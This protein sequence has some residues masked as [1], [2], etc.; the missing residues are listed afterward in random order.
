M[1]FDIKPTLKCLKYEKSSRFQ[2]MKIASHMT[3]KNCKKIDNPDKNSHFSNYTMTRIA[4]IWQ[5]DIIASFS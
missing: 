4:K 5:K 1:Q 3:K 2:E